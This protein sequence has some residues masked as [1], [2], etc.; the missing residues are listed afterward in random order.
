MEPKRTRSP[1]ILY[2]LP[3]P[4]FQLVWIDEQNQILEERQNEQLRQSEGHISRALWTFGVSCSAGGDHYI[5][6]AIDHVGSR[7][8]HAGKRQVRL[9]KQLS[10]R[11]IE[12]P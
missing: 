6:L 10:G 9:P 8:G 1:C 11:T 12:K 5:L 7:S 4:V 2:T 3:G